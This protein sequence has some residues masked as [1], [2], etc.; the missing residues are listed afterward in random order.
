[1]QDIVEL[2]VGACVTAF[3]VAVTEEVW[4]L[5]E[6]II[7]LRIAYIAFCSLCF[8]GLF[9]YYIQF[10]KDVRGRKAR[11]ILRSAASYSWTL[12]LCALVLAAI[13]KL[14]LFDDAGLAFRR[15]VLVSVPACFSATVVDSLRR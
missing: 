5:S 1:L 11:F 9:N 6:S 4:N 10:G 2:A 12:I 7:G 14:H 3:P 15:T 8:V 13:G